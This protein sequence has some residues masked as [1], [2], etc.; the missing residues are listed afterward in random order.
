VDEK[1]ALTVYANGVGVY[2]TGDTSASISDEAE[3]VGEIEGSPLYEWEAEGNNR[4]ILRGDQVVLGTNF[5][6]ETSE[7]MDDLL[8]SM[9]R[10]SEGDLPT[11]QE[12]DELGQVL[13]ELPH[14]HLITTQPTP[15]EEYLAEGYRMRVDGN[16]YTVEEII[17]DEAGGISVESTEERSASEL[18]VYAGWWNAGN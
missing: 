17:V 5:T 1:M 4:S 16:T 6:P 14:N 10:A 13:G 3:E 9:L 11:Y 12:N 2:H 15:D 18:G 7:T 8:S